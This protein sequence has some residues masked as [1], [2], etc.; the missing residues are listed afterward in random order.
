MVTVFVELYNLED[1]LTGGSFKKQCEESVK[2]ILAYSQNPI[3]TSVLT[4]DVLATIEKRFPILNYL[5]HPLRADLTRINVLFMNNLGSLTQIRDLVEEKVYSG[6]DVLYLIGKHN[7]IELL[8]NS[9]M[10][11]ILDTVWTGPFNTM[12]IIRGIGNIVN[13]NRMN[14]FNY[15]KDN[16]YKG[17]ANPLSYLVWSKSLFI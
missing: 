11:S 4:I 7:I 1:I 10:K 13:F 15:R 2:S 8:E 6:V 12:T 5:I 16:H 17:L 3:K 9:K 14:Q